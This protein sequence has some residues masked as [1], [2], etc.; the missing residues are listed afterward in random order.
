MKI[1]GKRTGRISTQKA[2]SKDK[3]EK[4]DKTGTAKGSEVEEV[5]VVISERAKEVD[6]AREVAGTIPDSRVEK[7]R[8]IKGAIDEG[9]YHVD[10]LEL[11][12]KIVNE[13]LR[14]SLH[15]RR[16]KA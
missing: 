6:Q 3:Q 2:S 8:A 11:A 14:E 16:K 13:A 10:S 5:N 4:V 12:K 7:V 9:S 1:S 15:K